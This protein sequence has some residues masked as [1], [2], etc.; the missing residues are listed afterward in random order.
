MPTRETAFDYE[1]ASPE[2]YSLERTTIEALTS[3]KE[4]PGRLGEFSWPIELQGTG[5]TNDEERSFL[6]RYPKGDIF[7]SFAQLKE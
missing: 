4:M 2:L 5:L 6:I 1:K 3:V 7:L